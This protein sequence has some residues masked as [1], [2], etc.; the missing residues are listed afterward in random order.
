MYLGSFIF[1]TT[2]PEKRSHTGKP[3]RF[4]VHMS[5]N[6]RGMGLKRCMAVRVGFEPTV[7]FHAR[8]F[9]RLLP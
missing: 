6:V 1:G 7:R 3:Y 9:S 5:K 8:Q 4:R 2:D